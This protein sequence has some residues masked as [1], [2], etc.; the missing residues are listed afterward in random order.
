M[1]FDLVLDIAAFI[2]GI[3][4]SRVAKEVGGALADKVKQWLKPDL[5][6]R[7]PEMLKKLEAEPHS[8]QMLME[9]P[10]H[11]TEWVK[12]KTFFDTI[13]SFMYKQEGIHNPAVT[14]IA[15]NYLK[16]EGDITIAGVIKIGKQTNLHNSTQTNT[17]IE[18]S[19]IDTGGGPFLVGNVNQ[20][21]P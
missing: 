21:A 15:D 3:F 20:P 17:H 18:G 19:D 11:V 16:A 10:M 1:A 8:E 7:D 4:D 14:S 6:K 13:R 12:D 9:L 2:K 5:D